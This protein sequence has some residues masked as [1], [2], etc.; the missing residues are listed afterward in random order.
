MH[1]SLARPAHGRGQPMRVESVR[2]EHIFDTLQQIV[3]ARD[4]QN[5][6]SLL[7]CTP[8][9]SRYE[10]RAHHT[11][12]HPILLVLAGVG[13]RGWIAIKIGRR[14]EMLLHI[15]TDCQIIS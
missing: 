11:A 1:S 14:P 12:N 9:F 5:V 4:V 6:E 8:M 15:A 2:R 3:A 10:L 13:K 7:R